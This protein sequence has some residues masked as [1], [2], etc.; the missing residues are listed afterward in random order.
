MIK[1]ASAGFLGILGI[2]RRPRALGLAG[3]KPCSLCTVQDCGG[4]ALP[5]DSLPC[6]LPQASLLTLTASLL[7]RNCLPPNCLPTNSLPTTHPLPSHGFRPQRRPKLQ[8]A[9][10]R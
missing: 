5:P 1:A 9:A 10:L 6:S 2:F 7:L 3:R 8:R 4:H